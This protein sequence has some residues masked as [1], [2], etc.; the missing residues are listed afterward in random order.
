MGIKQDLSG[1]KRTR[2]RQIITDSKGRE[3]SVTPTSEAIRAS[4][5]SVE[6]MVVIATKLSK[7]DAAR[8][9]AMVQDLGLSSYSLAQR[10][11]LQGIA[12]HEHEKRL[13]A[14]WRAAWR[15]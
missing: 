12:K 15:K 11:L 9:T 7:D 14:G 13:R 8:W 5:D 3:W 2:R 6:G 1:V 4:R 10:L